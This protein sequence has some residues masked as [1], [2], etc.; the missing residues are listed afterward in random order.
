MRA[1]DLGAVR[2]GD[3]LSVEADVELA[4]LD[5]SAVEVEFIYGHAGEHELEARLGVEG[6]RSDG[7]AVLTADLAVEL[8][9]ERVE[10]PVEAAH[11]QRQVRE[12]AAASRLERR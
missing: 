1:P 11:V 12:L 5:P 7:E 8:A 9:V 3:T 6:Q 4:G 2:S 10:A